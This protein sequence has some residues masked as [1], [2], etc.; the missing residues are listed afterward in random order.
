MTQ[1]RRDGLRVKMVGSGHSFTPIAVTDGV[2][3]D[4]S[5]LTGILAHDPVTMTVEVAAGTPLHALNTALDTLGLSLHNMGDVDRQTVAG[6]IST[7]THGTGGLLASLSA[8]LTAL[9]LV[10]GSGEQV[11]CSATTRPGLFRAAGVGLGALGIATS[12]TFRVEPRF[13]L[14]A[15]E[16]PMSWD[17]TLGRFDELVAENDHFEFYWFPHTNRC[18]TKR[19]NRTVHSAP[20]SRLR[21]LMDDELLA[22]GVFGLLAGTGRLLPAL[23]PGINKVSSSALTARRY[24][25]TGPNVFVSQRRVRFR[26]ME[27]AVPRD[28][29]SEALAA[30]RSLVDSAGLRV[31]FPIEVRHTL[32][33]ESWLSTSYGRDSVYLAFH[34]PRRTDH[35]SY[36]GQME[37]LLFEEFDGRPH[38]GKLHTRTAADLAPSYPRWD[39]FAAVREE[40]DPDRIFTN[41]YLDLVLGGG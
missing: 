14:E 11:T 4:P 41:A 6:A 12:L 21:H 2:L 39:D 36:F 20:L 37:R 40:V 7:G 1:A 38:W 16:E 10:T 8:Q 28:R 35:T 30:V 32:A 5:G 17:E 23:V 34:V 27:Y 15:V 13:L 24:S 19:N 25:D 33:D 9:S 22:N 18:L 3:L 26:E 31:G 29:A